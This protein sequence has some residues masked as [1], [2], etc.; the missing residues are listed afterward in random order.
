MNLLHGIQS[1]PQSITLA[2]ANKIGLLQGIAP[3]SPSVTSEVVEVTIAKEDLRDGQVLRIFHTGTVA[4]HV[5]YVATFK[6]TEIKNAGQ[7]PEQVSSKVFEF[8]PGEAYSMVFS[9]LF[10]NSFVMVPG[11]INGGLAVPPV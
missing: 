5:K 1:F 11:L 9:S 3:S 8:Y 6:V 7:A 4:S 10:S 2:R